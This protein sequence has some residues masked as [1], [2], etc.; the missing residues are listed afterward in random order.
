MVRNFKTSAWDI[1]TSGAEGDGT[2]PMIR[3]GLAGPRAGCMPSSGPAWSAREVARHRDP[4]LPDGDRGRGKRCGRTFVR[5][6]RALQS[7][8]ATGVRPTEVSRDAEPGRS[9]GGRGRGA[10]RGIAPRPASGRGGTA[11]ST[12][13]NPPRGARFRTW[14]LPWGRRRAMGR[15][16]CAPISPHSPAGSTSS[17]GC[18]AS[19]WAWRSQSSGSCLFRR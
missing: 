14:A 13:P 15:T 3:Q 4:R 19:P 6:A 7:T 16:V 5:A 8:D 9:P 18:S 2:A 1:R 11:E 17:A 12:P 10:H